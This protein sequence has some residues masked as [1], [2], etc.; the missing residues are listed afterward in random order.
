[1]CTFR[2][3]S[4]PRDA[5]PLELG[6]GA[7][8]AIAS[9]GLNATL[10]LQNCTLEAIRADHAFSVVATDVYSDDPNQTVTT[11]LTR[12]LKP[13]QPRPLTELATRPARAGMLLSADDPWFVTLKQTL[14]AP[15][16][17]AY[18]TEEFPWPVVEE[19]EPDVGD[20]LS[21]EPSTPAAATAPT[22]ATGPASAVTGTPSSIGTLPERTGNGGTDSGG[23]GTGVL[24]AIAL[25]ALALLAAAIAVF[26][27]RKRMSNRQKAAAAQAKQADPAVPEHGVHFHKPGTVPEDGVPHTQWP[28]FDAQLHR[29]LS[30]QG[31]GVQWGTGQHRKQPGL[32]TG[33]PGYRDQLGTPDEDANLPPAVKSNDTVSTATVTAFT[34]LTWSGYH[35]MGDSAGS[36]SEELQVA[37]DAMCSMQEPLLGRYLPLSAAQRRAGGQGVV[38]FATVAHTQDQ[39]AIKFYLDR[40]AFDMEREL[41]TESQLKAMMPAILAVEDNTSGKAKTPY[42]Y[43]FPPFVIIERGQS[44][45]EWARDNANKDFITIFQA[46]SHAVRALKGLH[47]FGYAHRDIK[48]GNILRRPKQHDWTLLDFGCTARIGTMAS[49]SFSLKYAAPEVVHALEAGSKTILAETAVD[50]WAIGVIAYELLTEEP[51]FAPFNMSAA[52][53]NSSAQEAIAGRAPL[54]WEEGSAEARQRLGK[55]RGMRRSVLRCL[56]R[57]PAQRPSAAALLQSWDHKFDSMHTRGTTVIAPE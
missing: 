16:P 47:E 20:V 18:L 32:P 42:G 26:V 1:M 30:Q 28:G 31:H 41:Y 40:K 37:L 54:P 56:N 4:E 29:R 19:P 49:L 39:A 2:S 52:Q 27:G 55:L 11:L 34:N 3:L 12:M 7:S 5:E 53:S 21:A 36:A 45:D 13:S 23:V 50:I 33:K 24:V 43:V 44:L 9:Q 38:Q 15:L 6:E 46:V 48:P 25:G 14:A 8:A 57:D 17:S 22:S 51:A 10:A 35:R